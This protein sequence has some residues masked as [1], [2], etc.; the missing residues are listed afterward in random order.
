M[1]GSGYHFVHIHG[2]FN[3]I[4][5]YSR[6]FKAELASEAAA[7]ISSEKISTTSV[8]STEAEIGVGAAWSRLMYSVRSAYVY[9]SR[10]RASQ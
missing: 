9:R 4:Y 5:L 6:V 10:P 7:P 3:A 1:D 8:P 2:V